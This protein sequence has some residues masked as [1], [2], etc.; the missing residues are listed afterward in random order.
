MLAVAACGVVGAVFFSRSI[1]RQLGA[2]PTDLT[3]LV[4]RV[5][6]GDLATPVL[7]QAGDT[8]SVMALLGQMQASLAQVVATVRQNSESVATASAQIAQGNQDLSSRTEQQASALQQTASTMEQLGATLRNNADSAKQAN[9][10]AQG[11]SAV[12]AQGGEV[13][14]KVVTTMQS[15]NDSS[16]K[17]GDIISVIDGIAFQTNILALN[18]AVEAARAGEQG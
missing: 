12:A 7:V 17:I 10:L 2:D 3:T 11:A 18:A 5:T 14:G 4:R 6:A 15:I 1:V 8:E 13:V 16:S 9:Q